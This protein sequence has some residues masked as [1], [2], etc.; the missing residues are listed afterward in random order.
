MS[1]LMYDG[2]LRREELVLLEITDID[3]AHREVTL[4]PEIC[5]NESGRLVLFT[6]ATATRLR[7]Y[8]Q[9]RRQI[10]PGL[11][12]LFLSESNR[13]RASGL[14][15]EMVNKVTRSIALRAELPQFHPH[16]LR[17]LRLTHMARCGIAEHI[18]AEYAGHKSLDTT[19]L[20]IH[21]SGRDISAAVASRMEEFEAW[22]AATLKE[23]ER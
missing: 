1:L 21:M 22:I 11:G 3:W 18:I 5:K 12:L 23:V 15:P 9:H 4:R 19:R 8:L 14:T 2:A 6:Q 7:A 16:T 20:Y 10:K 13:N 17:H